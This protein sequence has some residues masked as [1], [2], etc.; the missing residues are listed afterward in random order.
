MEWHEE[1]PSVSVNLSCDLDKGPASEILIK[2]RPSGFKAREVAIKATIA[3]TAKKDICPRIARKVFLGAQGGLCHE[4]S[5]LGPGPSLHEPPN[6]FSLRHDQRPFLKKGSQ[7]WVPPQLPS[8][9]GPLKQGV[10]HKAP[11]PHR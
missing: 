7:S 2:P 9:L 11:L 8:I 3:A 5:P 6:C 1:Q 4:H 10:R